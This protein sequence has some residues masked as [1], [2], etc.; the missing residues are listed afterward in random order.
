MH[1][2]QRRLRDALSPDKVAATKPQPVRKLKDMTPAEI[3]ELE[4]K[5]ACKVV[6]H[7]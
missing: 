3:S 4:K 7:E 2:F 1:K 6:Q 5:Y